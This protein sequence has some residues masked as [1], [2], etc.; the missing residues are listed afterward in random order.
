MTNRYS[1]E[2]QATLLNSSQPLINRNDD[3]ESIVPVSYIVAKRD[4][5]SRIKLS[6]I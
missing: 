6:D 2:Q 1:Q 5:S 3:N 4:K